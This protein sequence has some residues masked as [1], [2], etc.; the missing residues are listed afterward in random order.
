MSG[1]RE[2][3]RPRSRAG[4][5][6]GPIIDLEARAL[7]QGPVTP[8]DVS[9]VSI[10]K[11]PLP[12]P[13]Y[14]ATGHDPDCAIHEDDDDPLACTCQTPLDE[15]FRLVRHTATG[16]LP[17]LSATRAA[18]EGEK[19]VTVTRTTADQRHD[20][21]MEQFREVEAWWRNVTE[22]DLSETLPKALEYGSGDLE[23]M[24]QALLMLQGDVW[25]GGDDA[26]RQAIGQ[27]LAILFYIQGKVSR[28][29][30]A[31]KDGKRCS[32]DTIKDVRIYSVMLQRVRDTGRW[33]G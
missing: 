15:V 2:R 9:V 5:G 33:I 26:E 16:S 30:S 18:I 13:P 10:D 6:G 17:I 19:H 24:G 1:G 21:L 7:D 25:E 11:P 27:E 32:P 31:A 12:P 20:D 14:E 8:V 23:L 4:G 29:L 3:H 28:A 22:V